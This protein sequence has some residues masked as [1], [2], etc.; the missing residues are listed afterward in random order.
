M[1]TNT[2]EKQLPQLR[3]VI[4]APLLT[5]YYQQDFTVVSIAK[6]TGYSH[7]YISQKTKK[8]SKYIAPMLKGNQ[9]A[10]FKQQYLGLRYQE[11]V[12]YILDTSGK[13]GKK[14]FKP[15]HVLPLN[16]ASSQCIDK[17]RLYAGESTENVQIKSQ[18]IANKELDSQI[19]ILEAKVLDM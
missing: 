7:Q 17:S 8:L 12:E 9:Y 2:I 15:V 3:P 13:N 11:E 16:T 19:A 18:R 4:D 14:E 1:V 6:A 10:A 5:A